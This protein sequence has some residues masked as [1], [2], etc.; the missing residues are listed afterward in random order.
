MVRA[1]SAPWAMQSSD[2]LWTPLRAPLG[3]VVGL[4]IT[5]GAVV[6]MNISHLGYFEPAL[7]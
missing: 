4:E 2:S 6:L 3:Q 5:L 1:A 7:G